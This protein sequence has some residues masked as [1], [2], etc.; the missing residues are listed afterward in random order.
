MSD[1]VSSNG[2]LSNRLAISVAAFVWWNYYPLLAYGNL[3][4]ANGVNLIHLIMTEISEIS[5]KNFNFYFAFS[6]G[7]RYVCGVV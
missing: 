5:R 7:A 1:R 6:F 3:H 2:F 4:G